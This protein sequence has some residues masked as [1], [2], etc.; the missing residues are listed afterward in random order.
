M[1]AE[2]DQPVC[3]ESDLACAQDRIR[4]LEAQLCEAEQ[5]LRA[6][7][8][9]IQ[10]QDFRI[11]ELKAQLEGADRMLDEGAEVRK[12]L[13]CR[14]AEPEAAGPDEACPL[15]IPTPLVQTRRYK[16]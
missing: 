11:E 10:E 16:E 3:P 5:E 6:A 4:R 8:A 1:N 9:I 14:L 2:P 15:V 7:S 12:S 13:E